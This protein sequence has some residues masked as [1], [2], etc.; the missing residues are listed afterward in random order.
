L[1]RIVGGRGFAGFAL[2]ASRVGGSAK[3]I[4]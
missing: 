4:I 1:A 3:S 2:R